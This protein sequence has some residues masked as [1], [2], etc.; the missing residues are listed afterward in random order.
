MKNTKRCLIVT[1]SFLLFNTNLK[2]QDLNTSTKWEN[3][4]D[5]IVKRMAEWHIPG[6]A[7]TI[8]KG[9][10]T[11][12]ENV[13]GY[14]NAES[15]T[16]VTKNTL[17]A[18]GSCTKF[19]TTTGLSILSD[20]NKLDFNAPVISY[21][22]SLKLKDTLLQNEITVKDILSHRTGLE[23][24]DY[25]WYGE[26]Y[27]REEVLERLVHLNKWAGIRDAFIYNNMMYT[28][29]GTIIEKQSSLPYETF[30]EQRLFQPI[31]MTNTVFN[32]SQ[33]KSSYALPYGYSDNKYKLLEMPKLKG[34]EPAGAI[35]SD[36]SDMSKWLKF[37]LGTGKI[38]TS[39]VLSEKSLARLKKPIYYTGQNMR[40]DE[41][42]FKSYGLGAG[43]SAYKGYRVMYHTGVAGG[44]TAIFAFLPEEN[45]GVVILTNTDTY[46]FAMMNNAFD[47]ALGLTQ[48]DWNSPILNAYNEQKK[49]E[50]IEANEQQQKIKNSLPVNKVNEYVGEYHHSFKKLIKIN[51]RLNKLSLVYNQTEY[52]LGHIKENEFMAYDEQI[53]G[54]IT[55]QFDFDKN[56]NI[57][58]LNLQIMGQKLDY[59]KEK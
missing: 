37:H 55:V 26:N 18:I 28:L 35:W 51:V 59:V 57:I 9:D 34:V 46:L 20:E 19:F 22:P 5:T 52:P 29:A 32:L 53:F 10:S 1:T 24:G 8:V 4:S 38:D 50:V 27:N 48:T 44:Y 43:F 56:K 17:F 58:G 3:F 40:A 36:I 21:Y 7:I 23:S 14:S 2:S 45:I 31:K 6:M 41:T 13:Y 54:E 16:A 47:N 30:I 49:E 12:F 11:L 15:K 39:Q 42:E 25:I 33:T